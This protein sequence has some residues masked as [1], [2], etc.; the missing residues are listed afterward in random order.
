[1]KKIVYLIE[2]PLDEWN[3]E[4][5]GIQTWINRGWS[6]EVWDLT[7]L[8]APRVWRDFMESGRPLHDLEGYFPLALKSQLEAK[9]S[10]AG[11][12]GYFIDFTG[13]DYYPLRAKMS[14]IRTGA[15]RV[16]CSTGSI[17]AGSYKQRGLASRLGGLLAKGPRKAFMRLI[18][19]G[20]LHGFAA[21]LRPGLVI[22]SGKR[23][24]VPAGNDYET[25]RVH[26]LD[27]DIYLGLRSVEV[28]T[29]EYAVFI[30]Q[31]LCF[32]S[33]NVRADI[34]GYVTPPRY[35]PACGSRGGSEHE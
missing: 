22:V 34:D 31:D 4:R 8:V 23:S 24:I 28:P 2:Q 3:Y 6:V 26:N 29:E 20:M 15:M 9:C 5:F 19:K 16:S 30:D 11:K 18:S 33:D 13:D 1:M 21:P 27:Y 12:V 25:L 32:H 35:F 14:L 7:P 17:P 10:Q